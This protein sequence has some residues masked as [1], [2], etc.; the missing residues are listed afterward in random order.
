M[1]TE[2]SEEYANRLR[3]AIQRLTEVGFIVNTGPLM[4]SYQVLFNVTYQ[5]KRL[6]H[7]GTI[8][9]ELAYEVYSL[10]GKDLEEL[11]DTPYFPTILEGEAKGLQ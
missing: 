11:I 7:F 6:G 3:P 10:I 2:P 8:D 9:G 1:D 4:G 5:G